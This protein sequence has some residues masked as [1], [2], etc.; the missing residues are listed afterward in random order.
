[1]GLAPFS[2]ALIPRY[3]LGVHFAFVAL[4]LALG[5]EEEEEEV[6][7]VWRRGGFSSWCVF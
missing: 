3:L 1:M 7:V 2:V 4:F 6:M 5:F